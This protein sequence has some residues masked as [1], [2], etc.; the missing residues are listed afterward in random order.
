[1][2]LKYLRDRRARKAF[3]KQRTDEVMNKLQAIW[4]S[5]GP[6]AA[7]HFLMNE[8]FVKSAIKFAQLIN[9]YKNCEEG[10]VDERA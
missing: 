6:E 10:K 2:L 9:L 1:M 7:Y 8:G 3:A 5:D 4:D